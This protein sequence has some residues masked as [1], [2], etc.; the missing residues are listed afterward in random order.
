MLKDLLKGR[1]VSTAQSDVRVFDSWCPIDSSGFLRV[2]LYLEDV[3]EVQGQGK[4]PP[5][6]ASLKYKQQ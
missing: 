5:E 6:M 3:G 1:L 2:I 4:L